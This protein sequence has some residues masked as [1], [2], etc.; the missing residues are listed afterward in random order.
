MRTSEQSHSHFAKIAPLQTGVNV[1]IGD[2]YTNLN[3]V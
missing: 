1:N 2:I 3:R